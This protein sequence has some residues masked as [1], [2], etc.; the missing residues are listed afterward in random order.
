MILAIIQIIL[1]SIE[2]VI[3]IIKLLKNDQRSSIR[4]IPLALSTCQVSEINLPLL[5]TAPSQRCQLLR[6][7]R[8]ILQN[9]KF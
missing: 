7:R 8:F 6:C 9:Y 2:I 3:E 5:P 4:S 1:V